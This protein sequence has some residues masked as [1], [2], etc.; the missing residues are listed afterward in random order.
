[1]PM[2]LGAHANATPTRAQ[3]TRF[4]QMSLDMSTTSGT[5]S[6]NAGISQNSA[7]ATVSLLQM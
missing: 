5:S 4:E 7:P 3:S 6:S 1:M 2:F